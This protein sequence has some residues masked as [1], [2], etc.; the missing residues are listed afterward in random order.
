LGKS[1]FIAGRQGHP[2]QYAKRDMSAAHRLIPL[3]SGCCD[4]PD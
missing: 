1:T 4:A 2:Y 3:P